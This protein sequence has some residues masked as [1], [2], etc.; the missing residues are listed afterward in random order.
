MA[1]SF[2]FGGKSIKRVLRHAASCAHRAPSASGPG[3]HNAREVPQGGTGSASGE[4]EGSAEVGDGGK[5]S[6]EI[7]E[8]LKISERTVKYH[9][10]NIMQKVHAVTR[11]QAVAISVEE[12]LIDIE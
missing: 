6:W 12:G 10:Q 2:S 5:S 11:A 1:S 4:R 8:I 3:S 9:V 7:S